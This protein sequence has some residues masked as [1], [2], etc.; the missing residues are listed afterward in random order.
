VLQNEICL[1][2]VRELAV[3][4]VVFDRPGP[5]F[6]KIA[7]G[8]WGRASGAAKPIEPILDALPMGH[9][10]AGFSAIGILGDMADHI[11]SLDGAFAEE[12]WVSNFRMVATERPRLSKTHSPQIDRR[13]HLGA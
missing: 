8:A 4:V 10:R 12:A 7:S 1:A 6:E 3:R 2:G 9:K 13:L 11:A 5:G